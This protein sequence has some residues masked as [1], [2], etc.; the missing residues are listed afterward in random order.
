MNP[1]STPDRGLPNSAVELLRAR[2]GPDVL[3]EAPPTPARR[4]TLDQFTEA[5]VWLLLAAEL[6][7]EANPRYRPPLVPVVPTGRPH[8]L[9]GRTNRPRRGRLPPLVATTPRDRAYPSYDYGH[10]YPAG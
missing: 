10:G 7:A 9:P 3:A 1:A 4:Q 8:L 2:D 6:L 5:V